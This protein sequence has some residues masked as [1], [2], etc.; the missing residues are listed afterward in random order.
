[1]LSGL[2]ASF[3]HLETPQMP[4]DVGA[5]H[6]FE[7]PASDHGDFLAD[8]RTRT[9]LRGLRSLLRCASGS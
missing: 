8:M 2:H 4:M 9:W 3:L 7:L 1:M 5:Q 6:T